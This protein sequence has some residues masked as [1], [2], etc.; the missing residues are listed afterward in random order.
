MSVVSASLGAL[1]PHQTYH[2]NENMTD[3]DPGPGYSD[4]CNTIAF[5]LPN[6]VTDHESWSPGQSLQH[7]L[8]PGKSSR[9]C[10]LP[11]LRIRLLCRTEIITSKFHLLVESS[12][13]H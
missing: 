1:R 6:I 12:R 9:T 5:I 4:H 8:G 13:P 7:T 2:K 11:S 3:I 10:N